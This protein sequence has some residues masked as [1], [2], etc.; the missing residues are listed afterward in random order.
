MIRAVPRQ[1]VLLLTHVWTPRVQAHVERLKR[2]AGGVLDVFLLFQLP[3]ADS[4]R[5][6]GVEPDVVVDLDAAT[7]TFP[8]RVAEHG[9]LP[10][11]IMGCTDT[12]W[13]TGC[14]NPRLAQYDQFW[15]VEFDVDFSGDWGDFFQQAVAYEGDVLGIDLK[16]GSEEPDWPHLRKFVQPPDAP[17]D[18]TIGFFPT[19]RLS[20]RFV[21]RYR[22][23]VAKPG[24]YGHME[25]VMPSIAVAEGFMVREIGGVGSFTPPERRGLHYTAGRSVE[26]EARTFRYRPAV[27][28]KYFHEA[29]ENFPQRERLH[30]P[31]KFGP[32]PKTPFRDWYRASIGRPWVRLRDWLLGR[33][34]SRA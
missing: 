18:P 20:R 4:P 9:G 23:V 14:L 17:P 13:M 16:Y 34:R 29:P 24:W 33:R 11:A 1:C 27:S 3:H 28:Y 6:N 30:H 15:I 31:V 19:V 8:R 26:P 12:L 32:E 10:K 21:E 2:E 5:P 25:V 7:A 22:E